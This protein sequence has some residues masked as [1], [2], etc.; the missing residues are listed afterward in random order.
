MTK[1]RSI[2]AIAALAMMPLPASAASDGTGFTTTPCALPAGAPLP[3]SSSTL[4]SVPEPVP[5]VIRMFIRT[6]PGALAANQVEVIANPG[7]TVE[8]AVGTFPPIDVQVPYLRLRGISRHGS[9]INGKNVRE[10]GVNVVGIDGVLVENLTVRNFTRHGIFFYHSKGY[11]ARYINAHNF[12]LY[13][14]YAFDSRCGQI[15]NSYATGGADS[16]FYVGECFP[17][18]ATITDI[19]ATGNALGYSGTNAGGNLILKNSQWVGNGMGIV[20][21]TLDGEDRPPQRGVIIKNNLVA[22]NN[23]K[24]AP[25]DG[26]AGTFYGVGIALAG[27]VMN[28]VYGNE[29]TGHELGGIVLA[30]LPGDNA[31]IP[32]GNTIWGNTV[33]HDPVLQPDSFDLGQGALSGTGNCWTDNSFGNSQPPMI[34]DLFSCGQPTTPPGGSPLVELGLVEGLAGLNGR[35]KGDWKTWP[36]PAEAAL[37]PEAPG[38]APS[39][40]LPEVSH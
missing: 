16:G 1:F 24:D 5:T 22:D 28:T 38:G 17:C 23:A 21:N 36:I 33:S 40:W 11:W 35:T 18:D 30:P 8:L 6:T 12:G 9:V 29:V 37:Q 32:S 7:D 31:W 39:R 10:I 26:L 13:G 14:V 25:S 27:G 4:I 19:I 15:D 3:G 20:P 2:A 34:E